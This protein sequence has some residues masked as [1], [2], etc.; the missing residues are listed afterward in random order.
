MN[1]LQSGLFEISQGGSETYCANITLVPR[2][3]I[4]EQRCE[5]KVDKYM[6]KQQSSA[7]L[8]KFDTQP[9]KLDVTADTGK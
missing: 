5:T 8:S 2:N 3:Q 4:K 7:P 6:Q 1:Y 9:M